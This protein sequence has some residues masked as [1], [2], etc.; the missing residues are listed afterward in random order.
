MS[1]MFVGLQTGGRKQTAEGRKQKAESRQ[2]RRAD[3][4]ATNDE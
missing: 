2:E 1:T 4:K 3:T